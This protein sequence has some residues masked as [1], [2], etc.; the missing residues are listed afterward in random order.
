MQLHI[1]KEGS[2]T[3]MLEVVGLSCPSSDGFIENVSY[4]EY[5]YNNNKYKK[6]YSHVKHR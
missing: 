4:N 1:N 3:Q 2:D 6:E 5:Y